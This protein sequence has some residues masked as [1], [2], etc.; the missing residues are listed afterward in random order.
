ML[1]SFMLPLVLFSIVLGAL[2]WFAGGRRGRRPA[3]A[4]ATVAAPVPGRHGGDA[5]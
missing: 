4:R 2:W 3:E 1:T 5:P